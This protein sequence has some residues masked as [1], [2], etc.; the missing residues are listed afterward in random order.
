MET[1]DQ[2]KKGINAQLYSVLSDFVSYVSVLFLGIV[3]GSAITQTMALKER[4]LLVTTFTQTI[5]TKDQLIDNLSMTTLKATDV[6]L[7]QSN[8]EVSKAMDTM[9]RETFS[10]KHEAIAHINKQ[11]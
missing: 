9:P 6:A 5:A 7:N 11:S 8:A 1:K 4:D 3:I 10:S 2:T